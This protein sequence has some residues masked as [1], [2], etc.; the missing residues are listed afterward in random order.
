ME[1]I[2]EHTNM[3]KSPTLSGM[4]VCTH[5]FE[6]R[7]LDKYVPI[8]IDN[9]HEHTN[10][11]KSPTLSGVFVCTCMLSI[12]VEINIDSEGVFHMHWNM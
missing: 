8:Y 6:I 11:Y 1:N 5:T 2:H 7:L 12:Y 9:I 3:Y 4:C 10:I